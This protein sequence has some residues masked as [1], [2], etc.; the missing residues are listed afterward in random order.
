MGKLYSAF[1]VVAGMALSQSLAV[2]AEAVATGAVKAQPAS[3]AV[4]KPAH[5]SGSVKVTTRATALTATDSTSSI[6]PSE[7]KRPIQDYR[8]FNDPP[9]AAREYGFG[10]LGSI[11]SG[12]LGFYIGSGIETAIKGESQAHQGTLT[13]TGIRYDNFY[14]AFYGGATGILLGSSLTAFFVGETDEEEGGLFLTL[15]GGALT[16]AGGLYAAHLLGVNDDI[17]W[18]PFIPLLAIPTTGSVLG[19]N[20][21]RLFRDHAREKVVGHQAAVHLLPPRFGFMPGRNAS[22]DKLVVQALN[23]TF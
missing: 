13:F 7:F 10:I 12:A 5:D 8:I 17:H 6:G 20:I 15:V 16:T 14:G 1:F 2:S 11:V 22:G 23:L 19:Y 4:A 21:S 3:E 18:L 9:L